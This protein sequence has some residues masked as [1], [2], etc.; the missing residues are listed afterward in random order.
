MLVAVR[1]KE[2]PW[3]SIAAGALT[4]G[5]LQLRTGPASAAKSAAFGGVL[6]AMIEGLGILLTK[7]TAPPPAP[8]MLDVAPP[9]SNASIPSPGALGEAAL[10]MTPGAPPPPLGGGGGGA[11]ASSSGQSSGGGGGGAGGFFGGWFGG[12][13]GGKEAAGS[14]TPSSTPAGDLTSDPFAPPPM[15]AGLQGGGGD[16]GASGGG[17]SGSGGG[18]FR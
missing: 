15:P 1:R 13:G 6:L 12:G 8:P 11:E 3:N 16:S 5:F 17:S 9:V 18:W 14:S 7:M 2:D 4:G 10:S